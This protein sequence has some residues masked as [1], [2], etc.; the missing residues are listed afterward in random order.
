MSGT[1]CG[2]GGANVDFS[3]RSFGSVQLRDSNPGESRI[4]AGGVT[5]NIIEN[6]SRMG[7]KCELITAFGDDLFGDYLRSV[8]ERTGIGTTHALLCPGKATTCYAAMNDERGDMLVGMSDMRLLGELT[9][10]FLETKLDVL[11]SAGAVVLDGNLPEETLSY[12]CSGV[13]SGV[14]L[15][16]DPVSAAK[17]RKFSGIVGAL[18]CIKPNRL[19]LSA[20]AG[21]AT[22]TDAGLEAA[23]DSLLDKGCGEVAVSLGADGCYW[24]DQRGNR[25]YASQ[26][27]ITQMANATGAGDAF[28]AGLIHAESIGF[29]SRN[30]A[31]MALS[32][33]RIA[34]M[35][36]ET[37]SKTMSH[38][39]L[40]DIME[41]YS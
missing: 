10:D 6:L 3:I 11:R 9:P 31:D 33:G 30:C 39:A 15:Y 24:A 32:A 4:S 13:L 26:S 40:M 19:E 29:S 7:E 20:I 2:V 27:P 38:T 14:K 37:V 18:H 23:A 12:L 17:A 34:C 28:L 21:M 5:R 25:F 16:A 41:E 8:C 1:V 35:S 22:D 36:E